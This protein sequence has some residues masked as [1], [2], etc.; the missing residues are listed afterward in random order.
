MLF[1]RRL[2]AVLSLAGLLAAPAAAQCPL[3]DGL[4]GGPCCA[5]TPAN[6][7]AFPKIV[8]DSLGICW[9]NCDVDATA[10]CRARFKIPQPIPGQPNSCGRFRTHLR[11][12]DSTGTKKWAGYLHMTYTRTWMEVDPSGLQHQVWRFLTHGN[13]KPTAAAGGPPCRVP[14]CAAAFGNRVRFTGYIDYAF[15]CSTGNWD[16]A[17]MLTHACDQIDHTPGFPRGGSFHPDRSYSFV[18]PAAGFVPSPNEPSEGGG[19]FE[20]VRRVELFPADTF[21]NFEEPA[22]AGLSPFNQVCLCGPVGSSLQWTMGDLSIGG[23]CGTFVNTPGGPF[24]PAYLSMSLGS[25]TDPTV[26]P[27]V[28]TLRYTASGLDYFDPCT[29]VVKQEVFYGVTTMRGWDAFGV[30]SSGVRGPLPPTFVD[31]ANA[32]RRSDLTTTWMNVLYVSD[33]IITLNFP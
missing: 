14:S 27:G 22:Q 13:L 3:P 31:Q 19:A 20:S 7:P 1:L 32:L 28:E 24:L 6:L 4:D 15:D 9:F 12:K 2:T 17:W 8:Q 30:V 26:F 5:I 18:G 16:A 25:W 29:G 23:A 11:L 21:C 33:H 10:P